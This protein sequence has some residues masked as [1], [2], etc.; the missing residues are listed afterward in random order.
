VVELDVRHVRTR[1]YTPK[2]SGKVERF[3]QTSL[4]SGPMPD[5]TALQRFERPPCSPSSII[6]TGIGH[7][8]SSITSRPW[9]GFRL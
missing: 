8:R 9:F 7:T 2:T 6:T 3:V 4:R 1:P 5:R